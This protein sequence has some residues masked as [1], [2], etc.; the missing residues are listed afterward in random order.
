MVQK[1]LIGSPAGIV[2]SLLQRRAAT[3]IKDLEREMGVTATAVRQQL[4]GLMA[5]GYVEQHTE[6]NGRGRPKY[7]Y[8]LTLRGKAL[9]PNHYDEF[10][11]SLLR[12]LLLSEGPQKVQLLLERMGQ[13]LA[14]EYAGQIA[15]H[16]PAER[17]VQFSEL[18]NAKG[19]L[20]EVQNAPDGLVFH[21]YNCPYYELAR[22]HRAICDMEQDMISL[23]VN[24][25]VALVSCTLD[26]HHGC[27][28]KIEM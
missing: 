12:E 15:G 26:G 10:T 13:R 19:I 2:L 11:N 18:L 17:A 3:T 1:P 7:V 25:P 16:A 6:R 21:E 8:T 5:D 14:A 28:F 22:Q 27:Q 24:Q 20:A 9:F 4:T 23:V